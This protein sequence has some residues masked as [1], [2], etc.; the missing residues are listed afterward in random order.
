VAWPA[1]HV[2]DAKSCV[3]ARAVALEARVR[4]LHTGLRG[5]NRR[6]RVGACLLAIS[7]V[8]NLFVIVT[9]PALA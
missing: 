8:C 2:D 6:K 5:E 3:F 9:G 4:R 7:Q 1:E